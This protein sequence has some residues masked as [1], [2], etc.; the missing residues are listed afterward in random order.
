MKEVV[1]FLVNVVSVVSTAYILPGCH[2][3]NLWTALVV[4]AVLGLLNFFV[5]PILLFF[6]IPVTIITLG[7]FLFVIN[8]FTVWLTHKL[9]PG[10]TIDSFGWAILFSIVMTIIISI[11]ESI[12]GLKKKRE[13]D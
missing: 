1:R 7:L 8:G 6:S 10:F 13:E 12:L 4:S 2:I 5:K 3:D 9:V 11:S